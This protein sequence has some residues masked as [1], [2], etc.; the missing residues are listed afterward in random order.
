MFRL[1]KI[2]PPFG[3]ETTPLW[4]HA[5]SEQVKVVHGLCEVQSPAT[6]DYLLNMGYEFVDEIVPLEEQPV[7]PRAES[8]PDKHNPKPKPRRGRS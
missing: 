3:T 2:Y 8:K 7:I 6:R 5:Y 1:R 4:E